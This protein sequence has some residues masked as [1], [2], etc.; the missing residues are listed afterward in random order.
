MPRGIRWDH[1]IFCEF[2][3]GPWNSKYWTTLVGRQKSGRLWIGWSK[4]EDWPPVREVSECWSFDYVG[5][6]IDNLHQCSHEDFLSCFENDSKYTDV[7]DMMKWRR[8][9]AIDQEIT[10]SQGIWMPT[11]EE[12]ER[13]ERAGHKVGWLPPDEMAK[14]LEETRSEFQKEKGDE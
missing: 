13:L 2:E 5:D 14:I 9:K 8:R 12:R 1:Q 10:E 11:Q 4:E 7:A 6:F 3:S